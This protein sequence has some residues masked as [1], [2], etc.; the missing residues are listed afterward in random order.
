MRPISTARGGRLPGLHTR[1]S[2]RLWLAQ[3]RRPAD[4]GPSTAP[5]PQNQ[6]PHSLRSRR[7]RA[8]FCDDSSSP[9]S[10]RIARPPV[11]LCINR[12]SVSFPPPPPVIAAHRIASHALDASLGFTRSPV[13]RDPPESPQQSGCHP[14]CKQSVGP[15]QPQH[16]TRIAPRLHTAN[17]SELAQQTNTGAP[18]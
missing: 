9:A 2:L 17:D 8:R 5:R 7:C 18:L 15:A 10:P 16:H 4:R 6:P 3:S 1:P 13:S 11:S 14:N 12:E